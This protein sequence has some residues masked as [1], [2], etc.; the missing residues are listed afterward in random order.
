MRPVSRQPALWKNLVQ[1][2]RAQDNIEYALLL[3]FV[4]LAA[5]CIVML[6]GESSAGIWTQSNTLLNQAH[7]VAAGGG[8]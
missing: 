4:I 6:S 7:S 8:S 3:A 2:E 1:D 5:C